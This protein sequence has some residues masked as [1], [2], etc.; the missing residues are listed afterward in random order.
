MAA[1][2]TT[3]N[4]VASAFDVNNISENY[5]KYAETNLAQSKEN[6]DK[7]KVATDEATKAIETALETAKTES[8]DFGM[9]AID[10]FQSN[11]NASLAH[12][13][14]L[15]SVK[16]FSEIVDL[17]STYFREQAETVSAQVKTFQDASTK[18]ATDVSAPVK[19]VTEKAI[20]NITAA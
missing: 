3:Q 18:F 20:K 1:K 8:A 16:S 14:K 9:K 5:R 10:V 2:K 15:L 12:T 7:I 13:E 19:A 17:Q 6:F 11:L 4:G